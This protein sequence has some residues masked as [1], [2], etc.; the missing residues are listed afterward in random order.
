MESVSA[1]LFIGSGGGDKDVA[2]LAGYSFSTLCPYL[3]SLEF[4]YLDG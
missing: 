4:L 3:N 1:L 2:G